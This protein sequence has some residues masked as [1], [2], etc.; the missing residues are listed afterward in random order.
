MRFEYKISVSSQAPGVAEELTNGQN[1]YQDVEVSLTVPRKL[2]H[3]GIGAYQTLLNTD[4]RCRRQRL[5]GSG[6]C[7]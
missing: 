6:T 2:G 7:G 4:V 1:A 5:W 3:Y